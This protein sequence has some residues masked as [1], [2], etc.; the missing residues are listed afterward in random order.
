MDL[1]KM[2]AGVGIGLAVQVLLSHV[3]GHDIAPEA[4]ANHGL[5]YEDIVMQNLPD[6]PVV[7][8]LVWA[9]SS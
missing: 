8:R 2:S 6:V 7:Q 1:A 9:T 5:Y 3:A 4:Q